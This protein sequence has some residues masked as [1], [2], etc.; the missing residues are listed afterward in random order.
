MKPSTLILWLYQRHAL[1]AFEASVG[2]GNSIL[3]A[4]KG[5]DPL[6]P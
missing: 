3:V 4:L 2:D 5:G 6:T 1:K